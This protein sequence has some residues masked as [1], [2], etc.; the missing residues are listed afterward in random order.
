MKMSFRF[1]AATLVSALAVGTAA[2]AQPMPEEGDWVK[3]YSGENRDNN[4]VGGDFRLLGVGHD[5]TKY[6]YLSFCLEFDESMN[7]KT[8]YTISSIS[9]IAESRANYPADKGG[10]SDPISNATK[11]LMNEYVFGDFSGWGITETGESLSTLVQET[12]WYFENEI[13]SLKNTALVGYITQQM[14]ISMVDT[15][16]D[17]NFMDWIKVVNLKD[18]STHIQSQLI[19]T[20]SVP[21]PATLLLFGAGLA[22]VAGVV[23]RKRKPTPV[24]QS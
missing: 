13:K 15:D 17:S 7:L 24:L 4:F 5:G 16:N 19:A 21:E 6:S 23:R 11:Y 12:I 14:N 18:N 20:S 2:L 1:A 22:G 9:N 10:N 3:I 8:N